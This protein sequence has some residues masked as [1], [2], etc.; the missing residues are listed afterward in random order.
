MKKAVIIS[1]SSDI[2]FAISEK[3]IAEGYK[4]VGTY[5]NES[6][7][8]EKL[9][10]KGV[11]LFNCDLSNKIS[12]DQTMTKLSLESKNWNSIISCVGT[13]E[14]VGL[15]KDVN[16]LKWQDSF[17]ANF[18][19]QFA[20]IHSLIPYAARKIKGIHPSIVLFAGGGTNN[21]PT[22]Y[23]AYISA[24]VLSIKL[25]ELLNEEIKNVSFSIVGPGW[26]KTKI[27]KA[28]LEAGP[29]L[30]GKSYKLTKEKLRSGDM[31]PMEKVVKYIYMLLNSEKNVVGGRN[32]SI[33]HDELDDIGL[34]EKLAEDDD[35]FKLRRHGN[36]WKIK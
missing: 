1:I 27:H 21:A 29:S 31:V 19:S 22:N 18:F 2:G 5:R 17:Q 35:M 14:P 23:S 32:F 3:L 11:K 24:K 9:R 4:V 10:N 26:V 7:L 15:F 20:I 36:N 30:S 16:F 25:T 34:V 6:K 28:T 13:Q 8:V 12:I 33:V